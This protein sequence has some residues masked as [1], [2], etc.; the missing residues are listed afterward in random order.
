MYAVYHHQSKITCTQ[1]VKPDIT[2]ILSKV[3][4][5]LY[6]IHRILYILSCPREINVGFTI[7]SQGH[8]ITD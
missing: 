6:Q 1:Y 4:I 7:I 3:K 8:T 5:E 2:E